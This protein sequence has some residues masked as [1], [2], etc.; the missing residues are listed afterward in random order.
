LYSPYGELEAVVA[1]HPF[2]YGERSERLSVADRIGRES[3]QGRE[4]QTLRP[5]RRTR[6]GSFAPGGDDG[7]VDADDYAVTTNGTCSGTATGDCRRL[8]ANAAERSEAEPPAIGK[9]SWIRASG[10]RGCLERASRMRTS[11]RGVVDSTD[12]TAIAAYLA[13]L[14]S[15]TELQRVP[16]A[17]HSRRGNLFAHQGLVLDSEIGSYQNRA[18]QYSPRAKRFMQRDPLIY[19]GRGRLG[20]GEGPSL[21]VYLGNRPT[22]RIDPTGLNTESSGCEECNEN[23]VENETE[24]SAGAGSDVPCTNEITIGG[25]GCTSPDEPE[26]ALGVGKGENGCD[27]INGWWGPGDIR[28]MLDDAD[29][30]CDGGVKLVIKS[31]YI[32]MNENAM[33]ILA[34]GNPEIKQVCGCK[35]R[36]HVWFGCIGIPG[37]RYKCIDVN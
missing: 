16:A 34:I 20:F 1:A 23:G 29:V 18:R 32:G 26:V 22:R 13:T 37:L 5:A 3:E 36:Y 33:R 11:G 17:T 15:D 31:C 6:T 8:D 2:D 28:D 14:D 4:R 19:R 10:R 9:A 24:I 7:D 12:R 25:H 21:I 35:N 27:D 30:P